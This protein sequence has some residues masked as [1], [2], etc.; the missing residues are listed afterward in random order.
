M[1]RYRVASLA[2]AVALT[3]C[4]LTNN[5]GQNADCG[6]YQDSANVLLD[7]TFQAVNLHDY[8]ES[9]ALKI[10]RLRQDWADR[11]LEAPDGC[12]PTSDIDKA[13]RYKVFNYD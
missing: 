9:S 10:A 12:F 8:S 3:G 1:P 13:N 11:V 6:Y 5:G 4:G 7:A 2:L